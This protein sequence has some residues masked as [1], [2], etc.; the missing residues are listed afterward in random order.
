LGEKGYL[1]KPVNDSALLETIEMAI[2][3]QVQSN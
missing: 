1:R 2:G 3:G